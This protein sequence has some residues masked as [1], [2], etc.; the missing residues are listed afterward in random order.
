L[1]KPYPFVIKDT[2]QRCHHSIIIAGIIT[3]NPTN[4]RAYQKLCKKNIRIKANLIRNLEALSYI[5]KAICQV[6]SIVPSRNF[7]KTNKVGSESELLTSIG[8]GGGLNPMGCDSHKRCLIWISPI[9]SGER[10]FANR[11]LFGGSIFY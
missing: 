4:L 9:I 7:V 6:M 1:F 5:V 10:D 2:L 11:V 3:G 8:S